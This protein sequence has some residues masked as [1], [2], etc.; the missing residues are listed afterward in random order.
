MKI[1]SKFR[2]YALFAYAVL[3]FWSTSAS[4]EKIPVHEAMRAFA[5]K[6]YVIAESTGGSPAE[7]MAAETALLEE[8]AAIAQAQPAALAAS[9]RNGLTPLLLAAMGGFAFLLPILLESPDVQRS[10]DAEDNYGLT[11]H[12]RAVLAVRQS[13]YACHP[14]IEDPFITVPFV[15]VLPY[16]QDRSPYPKIAER[17]VSAGARNDISNARR[18]WIKNCTNP[19]TE[20]RQ[21]VKHEDDLIGVLI[22]ASDKV[23]LELSKPPPVSDELEQLLK[24]LEK[25]GLIPQSR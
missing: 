22:E 2:E 24:Q 14:V 6:I 5:N 19:D 7:W 20:L 13:L 16:Y 10:L 25:D 23:L 4:A 21:A 9:D 15:V 17:L 18:H 12:D 3:I 8:I 1:G 11:A